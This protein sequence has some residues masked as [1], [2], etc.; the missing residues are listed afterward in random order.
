MRIS[1]KNRKTEKNRAKGG[2]VSGKH[3]K[4]GKGYGEQKDKREGEGE[5]LKGQRGRKWV[6]A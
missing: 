1:E 6:A 5:A 4:N 2:E 3:R